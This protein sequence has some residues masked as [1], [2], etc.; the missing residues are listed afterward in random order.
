MVKLEW[1]YL[2]NLEQ[3]LKKSKNTIFTS[4]SII[5]SMKKKDFE[6]FE[7]YIDKP[8]PDCLINY[9]KKASHFSIKW[10]YRNEYDIISRGGIFSCDLKN[11]VYGMMQKS[12]AKAKKGKRHKDYLWEEGDHPEIIK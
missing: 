8:I 6:R 2:D 9:F 12:S 3:N 11:F 5:S 4:F 1:D 7:K 10:Y